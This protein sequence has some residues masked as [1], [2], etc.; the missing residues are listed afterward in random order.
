MLLGAEI[1]N[2]DV[3]DDDCCGC[4]MDDYPQGIKLKRL[5]SL[6][7]RNQTGKTSFIDAL[8][9]VKDTVKRNVEEA[10]INHGRPGFAKLVIDREKEA[11]FKLYFKL[12]SIDEEHRYLLVQYELDVKASA[13]GGPY[14]TAERLYMLNKT[15]DGK[16]NKYSKQ[17]IMDICN[18][19][20]FVTNRNGNA[21]DVQLEEINM[22]AL[23]IWGKITNYPIIC[24]AYREMMRWFFCRFSTENK[25]N[26]YVE[27]NAPGGHKHLNS[28]GSNVGNVLEYL[29]SLDKAQYD[30]LI[31]DIRSKIP[32]MKKGGKLPDN[33]EN[34]PDRL[35][36][37]LLLLR[38]PE[39]NSTIFIETPDK[40]LYHDMVDVL[41][42]EMRQFSLRR[43]YSQILFSTHNPYILE[44]MSPKEIWLFKREFEKDE[45]DV[46]IS[47]V[48][49]NDIVNALSQEG[50]GMGAIWYG[51][52]L[53]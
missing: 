45:G 46:T 28:D 51:G 9:F 7:G 42:N 43:G 44:T 33:V 13:N 16:E 52:Y 49:S 53:D 47:C 4:L 38:D 50:V 22:T 21:E 18:G 15:N 36:L 24:S 27:G 26:Y 25:N 17:T 41:S 14:I 40:D 5:T 11:S 29:E 19:R 31:D 39:P 32:N 2:Y 37:Y 20:G 1:S 34:S 10:S 35:F 48:G 30:S 8:N 23:G 3:F 12:P 6:I